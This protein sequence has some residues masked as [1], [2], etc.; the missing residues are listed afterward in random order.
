MICAISLFAGSLPPAP[1]A[2]PNVPL[3]VVDLFKALP[4]KYSGVSDQRKQ[5][6]LKA[7]NTRIDVRNGFLEFSD[8]AESRTQLAIFKTL[9]GVRLLAVSYIGEGLDPKT[10]D[11]ADANE[12]HILNY[13][14]GKWSDITEKS[15]SLR[16]TKHDWVE[17]PQTGTTITVHS[18]NGVRSLK[19]KNNHFAP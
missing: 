2:P 7:G 1:A 8:C 15:L 5:E 13:L 4:Q 6:L 16:L 17:L 9:Q 14:N 12:F 10:D 3:T 19:W 11:L 18:K